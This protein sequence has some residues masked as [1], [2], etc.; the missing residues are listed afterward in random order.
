L[1]AAAAQGDCAAV[2]RLLLL[3][4]DL[5]ARDARGATALLRASGGGHADCVTLLLQRGADAALA[6]DSGATCLSAAISQRHLRVV[7][8]LLDFGADPNQPLPGAVTPLMVAAALG[9]PE[10]LEVLLVRGAH[11][12]CR[13]EQGN[14]AI[15]ALGQWGFT[16]RDKARALHCWRALLD[17]DPGA[18]DSAGAE[19]LTPLLLLLGA[20]ADAGRP[21]DED[22]LGAQL[23]ILLAH[24]LDLGA[25][26]P[27][28]FSP[29]HLCALHGQLAALRRLLQADADREA[30][31]TLN[32][33]PQDIAVMR[34][35]VDLAAELDPLDASRATP[36]LARFLKKP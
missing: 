4:L 17:A 25:R 24:P 28:G 32:R 14:H 16:A 10:L 11:P 23:E 21:A 34:G 27:R 7:E 18:A 36:S 31:D 30:R 13:D 12:G 6:A 3:G 2:E 8:R 20:R 19:G 5:D 22:C 35:F 9:L 26:D 29:L 15:H 1:I 33:R